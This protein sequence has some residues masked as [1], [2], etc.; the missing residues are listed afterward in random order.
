MQAKFELQSFIHDSRNYMRAY[1]VVLPASI[2]FESLY[3]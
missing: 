3:L 2:I 1:V